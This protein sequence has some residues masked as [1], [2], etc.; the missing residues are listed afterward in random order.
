MSF[1]HAIEWSDDKVSR[2]W[3]YYSKTAPYKNIY[4]SKIFGSQLLCRSSLPFYEPISVLDFGCG[5]GFI[6]DHMLSAGIK[7]L[8]TGLDF[9]SDAINVLS[10]KASG[11]SQFKGA[12]RVVQLPSCLPDNSFDAVLLFEVVEHLNDEHLDQT[13]REVSR[14]LKHGGRLV[15]STPNKENLSEAMKFCPDCGAIFH[16]W[17]HVRSWNSETLT[18]CVKNY[19]FSLINSSVLDLARTSMLHIFVDKIKKVLGFNIRYPHLVSV[20]EKKI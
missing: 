7:W 17:Q 1:G 10:E 19:R 11:C 4:F 2:L 18:S 9:S 3:D 12:H 20:Y 16:E 8:Y 14:V 5:P 6:W 15:V 13:L